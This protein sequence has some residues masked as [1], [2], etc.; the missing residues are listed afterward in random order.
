LATTTATSH[1][2]LRVVLAERW[3]PLGVSACAV[4]LGAFFLASASSWPPHEDETL[5]LFVGRHSLGGLLHTV[6]TERGGAPLHFLVAWVVTHLGGGL[7]ALR[8]ASA[9]FAVAS[10]PVLAALSARLAGRKIGLIAVGLASA[11]WLMLFHGVYGRMY[12]LFLL[13]SALSYLALLVAVERGGRGRWA[14]WVL[15]MLATI[16]SHPYGALVL[17]SQG[18]FVLARARTTRAFLAFAIVALAATPFWLTDRVLAGRFEASVG[19]G[20]ERVPLF[21]YLADVAGDASS[22]FWPVLIPIL[23]FA[24][25]GWWRLPRPARFF[26][27]CVV[28]VPVLLLAPARFSHSASPETRHLVFMLPFFST[29][30]ATGLVSLFRKRVALASALVLLFAAQLGWAWHRT[31]TLFEGESATRIETRNEAS[32]WLAETARPDDVLF[33]YNP[34][35]LGAW[36]QDRHFP[37]TVIPRADAKLELAELRSARSL[38]RGVWV[39]DTGDPSNTPRRSTVA[40]QVPSSAFEGRVFGAFLVL[41][42]REPTKTP[43]RYLALTES[44]ARLGVRLGVVADEGNL[45]TVLVA[46]ERSR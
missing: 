30:L 44:A 29:A 5:A 28:L 10:V 37:D 8:L 26:A 24:G 45:A 40:L 41:R 22:G 16:A 12:S 6:H 1:Y 46:E 34:V 17:A 18:V 2:G 21:G 7:T 36:E 9:L 15:A 3:F 38:G 13:T 31:P 20:A 25:F 19:E 39:L 11:S 35:F 33:G 32:A 23:A 42:S 27:G 43:A 14:L 4:G